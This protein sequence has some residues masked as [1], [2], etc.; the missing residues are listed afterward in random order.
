M[1]KILVRIW[2]VSVVFTFIATG[3]VGATFGS[4]KLFSILL[5]CGGIIA[6]M[7]L[8]MEVLYETFEK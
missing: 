3:I 1:H 5:I 2:I 7:G 8:L 4:C 6:M